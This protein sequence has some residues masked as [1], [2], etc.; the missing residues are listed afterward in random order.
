MAVIS[1]SSLRKRVRGSLAGRIP[2]DTIEIRTEET[3][4]QAITRET[5]LSERLRI[6]IIAGLLGLNLLRWIVVSIF[7]P[8]GLENQIGAPIDFRAL[9]VLWALAFAYEVGAV[10]MVTRALRHGYAPP[11]IARYV[12]A[13][14]E[15]SI[16][17]LT[18]VFGMEASSPA[19][20]LVLPIPWVYFGFILL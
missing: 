14:I 4:E 2:T 9:M 19:Y 20:L 16:P 15:T 13:F 5:L 12:N 7:F 18:L 10:L 3:F 11:R 8:Q 1:E 17:T 6:S